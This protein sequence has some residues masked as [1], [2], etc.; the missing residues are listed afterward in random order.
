M[1]SKETANIRA[2]NQKTVEHLIEMDGNVWASTQRTN[3]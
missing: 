2:E 1:H 3:H